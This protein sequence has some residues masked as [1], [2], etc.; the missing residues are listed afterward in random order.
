MYALVPFHAFGVGII[1][2]CQSDMLACAASFIGITDWKIMKLQRPSHLP[3]H[4]VIL[5]VSRCPIKYLKCLASGVQDRKNALAGIDILRKICNHPDLLQRK[6]WEST[7]QY[8]DPVR[9]GKLTVAMKV[10]HLSCCIRVHCLQ[11]GLCCGHRGNVFKGQSSCGD[12]ASNERMME[13]LDPLGGKFATSCRAGACALEAARA[14][15]SG[16]HADAADAGHHGQSSPGLGIQVRSRLRLLP[17]I[18]ALSCCLCDV[19]VVLQPGCR[20]AEEAGLDHV[21]RL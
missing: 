2:L 6:Q 15:G 4:Y 20:D 16:V 19:H 17:A 13:G 8:G 1:R 14:Q 7:K 3:K 18:P 12:N 9:S 10:T 5:P 11:P 21:M